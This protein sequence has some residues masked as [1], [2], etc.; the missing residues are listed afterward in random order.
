MLKKINRLLTIVEEAVGTTCICVMFL[1]VLTGCIARYVFN[2]PITWVEEVTDLLLIWLGY[3]AICYATAKNSHVSIDFITNK[4]S[5]KVHAIWYA[6]LQIVIF[7]TFALLFPTAVEC[8]KYQIRTPALNIDLKIMFLII[9][10]TCV[11]LMIHTL[12]NTIDL[13]RQAAGKEE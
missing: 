6:G 2:S 1:L 7:V 12:V 3:M 4:L 5:P 8:V 11:L 10:A 9:P 13:L